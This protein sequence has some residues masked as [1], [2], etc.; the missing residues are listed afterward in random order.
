MEKLHA[1]RAMG[2]GIAVDDFGTGYSSLQYLA[3]FPL[4]EIKIDRSFARD[5]ES[6]H[7]KRTIIESVVNIGNSLG[8]DVVAEGIETSQERA[9][10]LEL[11]VT[12]GQGYQFSMP[13]EREDF[14]WLIQNH[15]V[16][17]V[18]AKTPRSYAA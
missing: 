2:F 14:E 3:D 1:L 18:P 13:L 12:R 5:I 8:V 16:L 15:P 9:K 10:L 4:T 6:N 11:G 17:P 7:F